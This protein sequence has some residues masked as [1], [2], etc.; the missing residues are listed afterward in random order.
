MY[1]E[2]CGAKLTETE[3][4]CPYCG[5]PVARTADPYAQKDGDMPENNG[6]SQT[7]AQNAQSAAEQGQSSGQNAGMPPFPGTEAP[8]HDPQAGFCA[9]CGQKLTEGQ[10][11]CSFCGLP[12]GSGAQSAPYG[13]P[14]RTPYSYDPA[15][16]VPP[17]VY[18][19][20]GAPAQ[21][22][23]T[24]LGIAALA[25]TVAS[26]MLFWVMPYL[27]FAHF[28]ALGLGIAA[29]VQG[30]RSKNTTAIVLGVIAIVIAG[31]SS[32]VVIAA[33]AEVASNYDDYYQMYQTYKRT[34]FL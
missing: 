8:R 1:C 25:L 28:V 4:Q 21:K 15:R 11:V 13:T 3:T 31:I 24:A 18:P 33:I 32:I 5:A 10:T 16:P 29:T 23:G 19:Q 14:Y 2:N 20:Q 27:I 9:R 12:V 22:K 34:L 6:E 17:P 26:W 30:G 7:T